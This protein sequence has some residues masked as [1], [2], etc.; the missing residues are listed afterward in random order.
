L[1]LLGDR[2]AMMRMHP[3]ADACGGAPDDFIARIADQA[4]EPGIDVDEDAREQIRERRIIGRCA[5]HPAVFI[6]FRRC[7]AVLRSVFFHTVS[8]EIIGTK[9]AP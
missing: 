9:I 2:Y 5:K 1:Q 8:V 3:E 7:A 6:D 4:F